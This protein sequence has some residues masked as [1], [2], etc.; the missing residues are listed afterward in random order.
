[1]YPPEIAREFDP[2]LSDLIGYAQHRPNLGNVEG[3]SA[4]VLLRRDGI[5]GLA[6]I[7]ALRPDQTEALARY[8][9][10]QE[11]ARAGLIGG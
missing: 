8:V 6:A 2:E 5:D 9:A 10:E 7:D 3:Q 1:V 4:S 11:A